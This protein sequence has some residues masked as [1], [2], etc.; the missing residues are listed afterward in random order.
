MDRHTFVVYAKNN[1]KIEL[2]VR[3]KMIQGGKELT[4]AHPKEWFSVPYV[5]LRNWKDGAPGFKV[6]TLGTNEFAYVHLPRRPVSPND[7]VSTRLEI[8]YMDSLKDETF[9]IGFRDRL[10]TQLTKIGEITL[11]GTGAE[12]TAVFEIDRRYIY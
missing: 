12:K 6:L 2:P 10:K 3:L 8:T 5:S 4:F 9:Y 1:K 7:E 11:T